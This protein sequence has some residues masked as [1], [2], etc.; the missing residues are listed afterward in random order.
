M[1]IKKNSLCLIIGEGALEVVPTSILKEPSVQNQAESRQKLAKHM[2]LDRS[3]HHRAMLS[4][5]DS[6]KRGRP[7]LVHLSLLES[8]STPL[9]MHD[10]LKVIVDCYNGPSIYIGEK[11]RLPRSYPR[12]LG[13]IEKLL[14]E[15]QVSFNDKD[16]LSIRKGGLK[17]IISDLKP[18]KIIGMSRLG[19]PSSVKEVASLLSKE[20]QPA[21]I[22]GGFPRGQ[23][24]KET[25]EEFDETL[26][27]GSEGLDAHIVIGRI[28][29]EYEN[30]VMGK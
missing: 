30:L 14:S 23:F 16:L 21:L 20:E 1:S 6:E 27:L 3:Y 24:S 2:I 10:L 22:V 15:K 18:T 7:D 12:F 25:S 5:P 11:V 28:L 26:S 9:Y 4:L 29:Y 19:K 13:L 17:A 8:T